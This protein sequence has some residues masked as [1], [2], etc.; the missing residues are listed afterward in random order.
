MGLPEMSAEVIADWQESGGV[1]RP[2]TLSV[3]EEGAALS[4]E[5]QTTEGNNNE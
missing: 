2:I 3:D 5:G 4:G 1:R